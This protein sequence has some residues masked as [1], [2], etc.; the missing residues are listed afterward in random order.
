MN[1]NTNINEVLINYLES[2]INESYLT[3]YMECVGSTIYKQIKDPMKVTGF[4]WYVTNELIKENASLREEKQRLEAEKK[5]LEEVISHYNRNYLQ[6]ARLKAG[7]KIAY[8]KNVTIEKILELKKKGLTLDEIA[9]TL[10]VCKT[11]IWR[12]LKEFQK[13]QVTF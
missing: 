9:N 13:T 1:F 11:T 10:G 8:K 6:R 12:R 3:K 5:H 4:L 2:S 7:I